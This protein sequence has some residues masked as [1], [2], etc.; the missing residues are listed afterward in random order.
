MEKR[1]H[2]LKIERINVLPRKRIE[3]AAP[4]HSTFL[5]DVFGE[6]RTCKKPL[7]IR[8]TRKE[9]I[10]AGKTIS[11]EEAKMGKSVVFGANSRH[12]Y[13]HF[14]ENVLIQSSC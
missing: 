2:I 6:R 4:R 7:I 9:V 11:R 1:K 12:K 10:L 14:W 8:A 13:I 3:G 5:G